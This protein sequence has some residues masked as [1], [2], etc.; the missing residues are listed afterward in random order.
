MPD[1]PTREPAEAD[2]D[3]PAD[4]ESAFEELARAV[5]GDPEG[6]AGEA[7][8]S[9]FDDADED[10][11]AFT[12]SI[13][14]APTAG[15]R[16]PPAGASFDELVAE[17]ERETDEAVSSELAASALASLP[18]PAGADPR[19][20]SAFA[21]LVEGLRRGAAGAAPTVSQP[22]RAGDAG[23]LEAA[24]VFEPDTTTL[25]LADRTHR[26]EDATCASMLAH[27][28]PGDANL[29]LVWLSRRASYR[30]D[31]V[32]AALDEPPSRLTVLTRPDDHRV[33]DEVVEWDDAVYTSGTV[34]EPGE[35]ADVGLAVI[36]ALDAWAGTPERTVICIDSITELL[37]HNDIEQVFRFIHV[38]NG[39]LSAADAVVHYHM[40][41]HSHESWTIKTMQT[42]FDVTLE[43]N[44]GGSTG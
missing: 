39:R 16:A 19:A 25:L 41:T 30:Y 14:W 3:E 24:G 11:G 33:T 23:P 31:Q 6:D 42:L 9:P 10:P 2:E 20:D 22:A 12:D 35:L 1:D 36:R 34:H 27:H 18:E 5:G 29:L 4:A 26:G 28:P 37:R 15:E 44:D 38:L 32:L 21:D 13:E 43:F 40:D 8:G 17:L 7:P